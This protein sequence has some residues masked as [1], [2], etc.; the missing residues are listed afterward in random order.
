MRR[1]H[2]YLLSNLLWSDQ[3]QLAGGPGANPGVVEEVVVQG[4]DRLDPVPLRGRRGNAKPS[5]TFGG[6]DVR[7]NEAYLVGRGQGGRVKVFAPNGVFGR[8][9]VQEIRMSARSLQSHTGRGH[10]ELRTFPSEQ[11]A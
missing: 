5:V 3:T 10:I 6:R 8:Q 9:A 11:A 1:N 4:H 2:A 7:V